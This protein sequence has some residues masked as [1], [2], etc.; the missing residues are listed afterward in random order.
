M[1]VGQQD[2]SLVDLEPAE[3]FCDMT[4]VMQKFLQGDLKRGNIGCICK[5]CLLY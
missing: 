1:L 4:D 2:S 5:L 3:S